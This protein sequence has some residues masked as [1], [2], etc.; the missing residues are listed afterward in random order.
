MSRNFVQDPA[1]K[2]DFCGVAVPADIG[3]EAEPTILR[4]DCLSTGIYNI[5]VKAIYFGDE[6]GSGNLSCG[7]TIFEV[8][9]SDP[10]Q[11]E[12]TNEPF[13]NKLNPKLIVDPNAAPYPLLRIY[14]GNFNPTQ[15]DGTARISTKANACTNPALGLGTQMNMVKLW[16][17]ALIKVRVNAP[18]AWRGTTKYVWVEKGGFK[19]NCK[20]L[21][22]KAPLP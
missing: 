11:Y 5:Y 7:D 12:L 15:T 21:S 8:E 14:G 9:K 1:G 6:D 20:P 3:C 22:I 18:N 16:S 17:D 13:I 19:S 2:E 4:C 10:V